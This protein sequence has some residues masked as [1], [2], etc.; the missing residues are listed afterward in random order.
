MSDAHPSASAPKQ[1]L[2]LHTEYAGSIQLRM[3]FSPS[4][5]D[6]EADD[7]DF[8]LLAHGSAFVYETE[9]QTYLVTARHNLTGRHWQ[10]NAFLGDYEV[11]PTHL[12]IVLLAKP[13]AEGW[14][15]RPSDGHARAVST[16]FRGRQF[17]IPLIGEDWSPIWRQHPTHGGDVDV[18][19]LAVNFMDDDLVY[20]WRYPAPETEPGTTKWSALAPAHDVFV[21]GYP[22][23]LSIGPLF[24]LWIRGTV[25]SDTHF[26]VMVDGKQLPL[27]LVDAR[28]RTGQSG[29]VVIRHIPEGAVVPTV[30][31]S[32]G[33]T[34]RPQSQIVGV[35]SGRT[36]D[37]SDL[38]YVWPIAEVED[39]CRNGAPGT[40]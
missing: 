11:S 35:Y 37:E 25:A 13:P 26:G 29:S 1:Q 14:R 31:N 28:T 21:V 5:P 27:I 15:F 3:L 19:A 4:G 20:P 17:V 24:P 33:L 7:K 10:T 34:L 12:Q 9:G 39:I 40:L 2:R 6:A 16:E 23:A 18:A 30:E 36:S 8:Q 38:G 22:Y 32:V